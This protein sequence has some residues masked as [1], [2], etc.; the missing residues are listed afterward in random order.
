MRVV[1]A[2]GQAGDVGFK[3]LPNMLNARFPEGAPC[4][5]ESEGAEL[6]EVYGLFY[7]FIDDRR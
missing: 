1:S 5:F 2:D 7:C 4:L 6:G 3:S